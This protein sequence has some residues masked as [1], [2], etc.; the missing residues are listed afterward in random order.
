MNQVMNK[1]DD[2]VIYKFAA[3]LIDCIDDRHRI[4]VFTIYIKHYN[5]SASDLLS[6]AIYYY[7]HLEESFRKLLILI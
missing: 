5:E 6:T 4:K 3:D 2:V 7:K 1:W